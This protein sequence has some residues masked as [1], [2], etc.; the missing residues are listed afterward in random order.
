MNEEASRK[1]GVYWSE[2]SDYKVRWHFILFVFSFPVFVCYPLPYV[3]LLVNYYYPL[4][5]IH[6]LSSPMLLPILT[7]GMQCRHYP[8]SHAT[9]TQF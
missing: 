9:T 5:F 3:C 1:K 7:D 8:T 4:V 6:L 2:L